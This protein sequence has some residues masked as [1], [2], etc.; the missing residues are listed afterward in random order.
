MAAVYKLQFFFFAREARGERLRG[1][2]QRRGEGKCPGVAKRASRPSTPTTPA[3]CH[4]RFG[5]LLFYFIYYL[6]RSPAFGF[7]CRHTPPE[8]GPRS[9]WAEALSAAM[10]IVNGF[11]PS[12]DP[13]IPYIINNP[14]YTL[15]C[16]LVHTL[17]H[18]HSDIHAR[19]LTYTHTLSIASHAG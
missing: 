14:T 16:S 15:A 9:R 13:H 12:I 1:A 18:T 8:G 10:Y 17:R 2:S 7:T 4:L 19:T 6:F 11:A 3:I 5:Y